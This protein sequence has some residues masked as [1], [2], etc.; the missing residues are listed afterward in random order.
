M[1][2]VW[3]VYDISKLSNSK[4]HYSWVFSLDEHFLLVLMYW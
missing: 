4:D 2:L 1:T 3:Y